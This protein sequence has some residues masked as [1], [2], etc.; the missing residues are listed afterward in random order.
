MIILNKTGQVEVRSDSKVSTQVWALTVFAHSCSE[1]L[2]YKPGLAPWLPHPTLSWLSQT[3]SYHTPTWNVWPSCM[4]HR[5]APTVILNQNIICSL[6]WYYDKVYMYSFYNKLLNFYRW[7]I[8]AILYG[9]YGFQFLDLI[10][11]LKFSSYI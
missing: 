10:F 5:E 9:H 8:L 7:N 3:P 11:Y 2:W 1:W 4:Y 6:N